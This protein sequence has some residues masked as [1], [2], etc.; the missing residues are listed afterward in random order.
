[1]AIFLSVVSTFMYSVFETVFA[2]KS[3]S[4]QQTVNSTFCYPDIGSIEGPHG[5]TIGSAIGISI[6]TAYPSADIESVDATL[7]SA[8]ETTNYATEFTTLYLSDYAAHRAAFV[9]AV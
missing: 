5:R 1:L 4:I 2:A 8:V 9:S 3:I 6:S 7:R